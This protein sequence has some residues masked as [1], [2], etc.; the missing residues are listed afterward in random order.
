MAIYILLFVVG[1]PKY[2]FAQTPAKQH[3]TSHQLASVC[4]FTA[5][6]SILYP[7]ISD[8]LICVSRDNLAI[9]LIYGSIDLGD[10][11]KF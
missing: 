8:S 1:G 5:N 4:L 2:F 11:E 10:Y 6:M 9:C 3:P 7:S